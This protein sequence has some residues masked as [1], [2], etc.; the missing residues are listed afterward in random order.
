MRRPAWVPASLVLVLALLV[1][2][3][4]LG[5]RGQKRVRKGTKRVKPPTPAIVEIEGRE[6]ALAAFFSRLD[7]LREARASGGSDVV[8][9]LHWGDSHVAADYWTG[10]LRRLFQER[11]GDA[12][13]GHVMPGR[14]FRF[15]R[16]ARAKSLPAS[17]WETAGLGNGLFDGIYGLS[18]L[19]MVPISGAGPAA[20]ETDFSFFEVQLAVFGSGSC[21]SV[22]VD[23]STVFAG[24]LDGP[25]APEGGEAIEPQ[26]A[27]V[28]VQASPGE[29]YGLA[30][31]APAEPLAEGV[32]R[33]EVAD[34]CGGTVRLLGADFVS[35]RPGIL[36]DALGVNGAELAVLREWD[37]SLRAALLARADPALIV[38]S[39]GTNDMGRGDL[40]LAS[41]EAEAEAVLAEIRGDAPEASVLVTGPTD[42]GSRKR[43]VRNLLRPNE[44]LVVEA[45]RRAASKTGCAFWDT[46]A[47]MGGEGS[48][49][50]WAAAGLAQ[51]DL[52]HL[53]ARG[54][55]RLAGLLF[56]RIL[57][58]Y[59]RVRDAR[60]PG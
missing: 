29:P 57:S 27:V 13:T 15:H 19:G 40:D 10:E 14:P 39:Y 34:S 45:L 46:R 36:W 22:T 3:P 35:G 55:E 56:E 6:G 7:A 33:L 20:V 21:V 30:F 25:M 59:G 41:Y 58:A 8:R 17:G 47:A 49:P 32:H 52:V 2:F 4:G 16:H 38:V 43:R 53:T 42:R 9:V 31:V 11:F 60:Q 51:R 5:A 1:A 24:V 18:G 54:Y 28:E 23:G 48:I 44:V 37:P 50:R 26:C 12:G